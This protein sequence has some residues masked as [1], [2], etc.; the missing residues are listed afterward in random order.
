MVSYSVLHYLFTKNAKFSSKVLESF[1]TLLSRSS[2]TSKLGE[3]ER[4]RFFNT[5]RQ[6]INAVR[7]WQ[8][9]AQQ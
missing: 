8:H 9:V 1:E 2:L 6:K 7:N 4:N 3:K 5:L